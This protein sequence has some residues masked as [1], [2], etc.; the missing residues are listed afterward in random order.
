MTELKTHKR[1]GSSSLDCYYYVVVIRISCKSFMQRG[2]LDDAS[3]RILRFR[4]SDVSIQRFR[5]FDTTRDRNGRNGTIWRK[6]TLYVAHATTLPVLLGVKFWES[7][8]CVTHDLLRSIFD[9]FT[10]LTIFTLLTI[11]T[12]LTIFSQSCNQ[13]QFV[14]R[15][16]ILWA[17]FHFN[18]FSEDFCNIAIASGRWALFISWVLRALY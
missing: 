1:K 8:N 11:L 14:N 3:L 18:F 5:S 13:S 6:T 16:Y 4:R 15:L 17:K 10:I 7:K 9:S 2:F 12:I